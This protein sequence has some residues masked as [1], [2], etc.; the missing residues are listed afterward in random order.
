MSLSLTILLF[1]DFDDLGAAGAGVGALIVG[2]VE[3]PTLGLGEGPTLGRGEGAA[4]GLGEELD[5]GPILVLILS[6]GAGIGTGE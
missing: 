4:D 5:A 2:T 1:L 3:G 6:L